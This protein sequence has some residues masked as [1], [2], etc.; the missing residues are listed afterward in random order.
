MSFTPL[1]KT[2][3]KARRAFSLLEVLLAIA[4][5]A[6][7]LASMSVAI[8]LLAKFRQRG[9]Q[10]SEHAFVL[11]GIC[12]DLASDLRAIASSPQENP[13]PS[14]SSSE[15]SWNLEVANER[16]L[17]FEANSASQWIDF[18]GRPNAIQF[19]EAH[20]NPRFDPSPAYRE[21]PALVLWMAPETREVRLPASQS[22]TSVQETTWRSRHPTSLRRLIIER[23]RQ[24]TPRET[25]LS[26]VVKLRFRFF[27]GLRWNDTWNSHLQNGQLPQA[28]EIS[29]TLAH[30]EQQSMQR[31]IPI[32]SASRPIPRTPTVGS[33]SRL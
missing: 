33:S 15:E 12:E 27:D 17:D 10:N 4:I 14:T 8:S 25:P 5:L 26:D 29:L 32:T 24:D 16:V 2:H 6:L 3:A 18:V 22:G 11:L 23:D 20:A 28:V 13:T 21:I 7:I 30:G 19:R 9:M 31:I 1:T